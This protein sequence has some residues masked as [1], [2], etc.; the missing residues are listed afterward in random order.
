MGLLEG[1]GESAPS[2]K[3]LGQL[4]ESLVAILA[5]ALED[6]LHVGPERR[7]AEDV[8]RRG[9]GADG[10][11]HIGAAQQRPGRGLVVAR[12]VARRQRIAVDLAAGSLVSER[13]RH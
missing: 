7:L 2:E 11:A 12:V 9:F 1:T 5:G 10:V 4:L 3:P 6:A 13:A 8:A